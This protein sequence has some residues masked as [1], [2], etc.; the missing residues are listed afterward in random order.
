[1]MRFVCRFM[2]GVFLA[3]AVIPIV[4]EVQTLR[5]GL[6]QPLSLGQFWYD[7][8]SPSLN[9]FQAVVQRFTVPELWDYL[10]QPILSLPA[11]LVLASIA[12]LLMFLGV[13]RPNYQPLGD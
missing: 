1:M 11:W 13:R 12:I 4:R 6:W 7:V 3:L 5:S 9:L 8:N 2:G 10:F